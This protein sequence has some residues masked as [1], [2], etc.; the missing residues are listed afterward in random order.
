MDSPRHLTSLDAERVRRHLRTNQALEQYR[1]L[2]SKYTTCIV[3][4]GENDPNMPHNHN[5]SLL[6]YLSQEEPPLTTIVREKGGILLFYAIES[7]PLVAAHATA[8]DFVFTTIPPQEFDF[9]QRTIFTSCVVRPETLMSILKTKGYPQAVPQLLSAPAYSVDF[10]TGGV[11]AA[12]DIEAGEIIDA[13]R[14]LILSHLLGHRTSGMDDKE[15][16]MEWEEQLRVAV[17]R[18]SAED[19]A[20]FMSLPVS[21]NGSIES[22]EATDTAILQ[23]FRANMI[24]LENISDE[25][26]SRKDCMYGAVFPL[27]ARMRRRHS[28][29]S[30]LEYQFSPASFSLQ[31]IAKDDLKFG[32]QLFLPGFEP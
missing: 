12:R 15:V 14:P 11:F 32:E 18:M 17:D 9:A 22:Y 23:I 5:A 30:N 27:G 31:Y 1:E 13:E 24:V 25:E 6:L 21:P 3:D 7:D 28:S 29:H 16:E 19:Q 26:L 4:V 8:Y 10:A 2:T 20:L